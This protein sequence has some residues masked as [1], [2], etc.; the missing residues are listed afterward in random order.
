MK[1]AVIGA[2]IGGLS[3]ALALQKSGYDV[4]VY[5]K[6]AEM[7]P[8]GAA[9][10]VWSNGIK[11]LNYLG[12]H[13]K[14]VAVGGTMAS[15]AYINGKDNATMTQFSLQPLVE[16]MGERP[17]PISRADLQFM[18][19][20]AVG[21]QNVKLGKRMTQLSDDG[22]TVTIDFADDSTAQADLVVC[23]DGT[24]SYA[25]EYVT[26]EKMQRRYAGYVNWNG[27]I[28]IDESI[29][30][31]TQW[32]TFVGEGKRASLMP[33]AG[34][35]FYFFFDVPLEKGLDN[36]RENYQNNLRRYFSGWCEPVQ[37]L[38]NQMDA[39]VTNRVEI[40]DIEPFMTFYKGRVVLLGDAGHSTTPDLGQG[41]C[42]AME[43][44]V[45]L[46]RSL[47]VNSLG[48][49]DALARYQAKR[50]PRVKELVLKARKRCNVTHMKDKAVTE[51]WYQDLYSETGEHIMNGMVANMLGS[52]L[53]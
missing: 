23:A 18:L 21:E 26:G 30:P 39:S 14:V 29:A 31:A 42:Q 53:E 51:K 52:P 7:R 6:V 9:I 17:Y 33:I 49:E 12:L 13:E 47:Q 24:H 44:A 25:R 35:Q 15:L 50:A 3:A 38:I 2:G 36:H 8:V 10:S 43:D 41:G 11:C 46:A 22:K 20:D 45:Y 5:E 32:T 34:G 40:H 28:D 16:A 19:L 27:L 1:I 4:T 37:K 48:I